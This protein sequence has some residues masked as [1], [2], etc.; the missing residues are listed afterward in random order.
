VTSTAFA[1]SRSCWVR[2]ILPPVVPS[3]LLETGQES[4]GPPCPRHLFHLQESIV[5]GR[6]LLRLFNYKGVILLTNREFHSD[7]K[8]HEIREKP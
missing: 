8:K 6:I 4:P 3:D 5:V 2:G 1:A 7:I